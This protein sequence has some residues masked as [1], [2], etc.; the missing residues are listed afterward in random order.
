MICTLLSSRF[1][2]SLTKTFNIFYIR[3]CLY[4]NHLLK[5]SVS[6]S[7]HH[8]FLYLYCSWQGDL[9]LPSFNSRSDSNPTIAFVNRSFYQ[10]L[11]TFGFSVSCLPENF[12]ILLFDPIWFNKNNWQERHVVTWDFLLTTVHPVSIIIPYQ[13]YNFAI[14]NVSLHVMIKT[15]NLDPFPFFL[16][17]AR[18]LRVHSFF[19]FLPFPFIHNSGMISI[20][21]LSSICSHLYVFG[22][23]LRYV[24][25]LDVA[26][27][28][29]AVQTFERPNNIREIVELDV[30]FLSR[31]R[32][33]TKLVSQ[34]EQVI[35]FASSRCVFVNYSVGC[36]FGW[37]EK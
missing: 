26:S 3:I 15:V 34:A 11:S 31:L 16:F 19:N 13:Y 4:L 20:Y 8:S 21:H 27:N 29:F 23:T 5:T 7:T 9:T 33:L 32:H 22:F 17:F 28:G 35:T 14:S 1:F 18:T 24:Q 12:I 30:S 37:F 6:L 25:S 36:V 10:F 2:N